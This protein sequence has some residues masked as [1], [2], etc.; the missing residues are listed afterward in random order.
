MNGSLALA[1]SVR[2]WIEF[3][4]NLRAKDF[5]VKAENVGRKKM[6]KREYLNDY[7]SKKLMRQ[8]NQFFETEVNIP[9]IMHGNKQTLETLINEEALL[10]GMYLRNEKKDW[11]PR[12]I[13][14]V[15]T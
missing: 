15:T 8:L 11:Q 10:L 4:R 13:F 6:G 3:C 7:D 12:I 5:I 9:R 1:M 14:P 2:K